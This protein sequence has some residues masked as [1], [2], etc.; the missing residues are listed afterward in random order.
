MTRSSETFE[1]DAKKYADS[2]LESIREMVSALEH[3]QDCKGECEDCEGVGYLR[4]PDDKCATCKGSGECQEGKDSDNPESWHDEDAARQRI[5]EDALSVEVRGDWH[6]P[7]DEDSSKPCEYC[8]LITTGGPAA[9]IVGELDSYGQPTSARFEYQD[10]FKPW[11][12]VIRDREDYA[13]MRTYA[14][15]FY[16]GEGQ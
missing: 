10:W 1:Q 5:E 8:I 13:A 11:T 12:E 6:T 9:R 7:R 4:E 2:S 3:S 16:F 14:Q 15:Q